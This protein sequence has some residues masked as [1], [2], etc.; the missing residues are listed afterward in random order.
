MLGI[1]Q[2]PAY[3]GRGTPSPFV[4]AWSAGVATSFV[5]GRLRGGAGEAQGRI[6]AEMRENRDDNDDHGEADCDG[7]ERGVIGG[8]E[9]EARDPDGDQQLLEH[10]GP[11]PTKRPTFL[12]RDDTEFLRA[13]AEKNPKEPQC[14]A[15]LA[16]ALLNGPSRD[17]EGALNAYRRALELDPEHVLSLNNVGHIHASKRETRDAEAAYR[18]VCGNAYTLHTTHYTLHTT[19]YNLSLQP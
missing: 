18:K 10:D 5:G 16:T 7:V 13:A 8:V 9:W 3:G 6:P 19:H 11:L 1:C 14:W 15:M 2:A 17:E 4:T 12:V